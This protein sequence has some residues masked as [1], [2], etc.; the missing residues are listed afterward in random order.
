ME[1]DVLDYATEDILFMEYLWSV[2]TGS[3]D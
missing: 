1:V 3:R 2:K